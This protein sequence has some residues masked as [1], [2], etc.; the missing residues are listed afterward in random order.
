M[1]KLPS[2]RND[3]DCYTFPEI[4]DEFFPE[5]HSDND[6]DVSY[7][8][9]TLSQTPSGSTELEFEDIEDE[10]SRASYLLSQSEDKLNGMLTTLISLGRIF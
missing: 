8:S 1:S 7:F 3:N 5:H 4:E 6:S 10:P 9:E 2:N